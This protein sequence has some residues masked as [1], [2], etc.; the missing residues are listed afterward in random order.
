M[1]LDAN[2]VSTL[3]FVAREKYNLSSDDVQRISSK[4][5]ESLLLKAM[6]SLNVEYLQ[7]LVILVLTDIGAKAWPI[8][9]SLSRSAEYLQLSIEEDEARSR[10]VFTPYSI[11]S[12]SSG[13]IEEEE[14]RRLF[15]VI[16]N[17][18]SMLTF[19]EILIVALVGIQARQPSE[20]V[21]T[22]GMRGKGDHIIDTKDVTS[23]LH[24]ILHTQRS[25]IEDVYGS[26]TGENQVLAIYKEVLTQC[27]QGLEI[28]EDVTLL[29][30]DDNQGS[31][32]R[33]LVGDE[34][35]RSGGAGIYYHFEFVGHPRNYKWLN[36]NHLPKRGSSSTKHTTI[37]NVADIK[38]IEVPLSFAMMKAWNTHALTPSQLPAFFDAF[39]DNTFSLSAVD[40]K[41]CSQ[42]LFEYDQ[43]IGLGKHECIEDDTFSVIYYDEADSVLRR[44]SDLLGR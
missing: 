15:W 34:K 29:F 23:T 3:K 4:C 19:D 21:L 38:P 35:R 32:P 6:Q 2:I 41:E 42:L 33:L 30:E 44:W 36:S 12:A 7:A 1:I 16:F 18:D 22:L 39:I 17:L 24:G 20:S 10:R 11:L 25:I 43:L 14:R 40:A 37:F 26:K 8:I 28:P 31:I 9:G 27:D 5:R 13:W